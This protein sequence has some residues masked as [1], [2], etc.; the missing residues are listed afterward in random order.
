MLEQN[1]PATLAASEDTY[2]EILRK[3]Q[4]LK[5]LAKSCWEKARRML[6][7]EGR[8]LRNSERELEYLFTQVV[9][10]EHAKIREASKAKPATF[11]AVIKAK[12]L[13]QKA[14]SDLALELRQAR[15][16]LRDLRKPLIAAEAT[17]AVELR[18]M[19]KEVA[20]DIRASRKRAAELRAFARTLE[21]KVANEVRELW[22]RLSSEAISRSELERRAGKYPG[23]PQ[24]MVDATP[25]GEGLPPTSGIYFLWEA[26]KVVYVGKSIRLCNRLR[27][28]GHH[29]LA[30]GHRISFVLIPV[31]ELDWAE[32]FYI[33]VLRPELNFGG[34]NLTESGSR[35]MSRSAA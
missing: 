31:A 9:V 30:A 29:V 7:P 3:E 11:N 4:F 26:E 2:A 14:R 13:R 24:P 27:R 35:I 32:S 33:G 12:E 8:L 5:H 25:T 20:D 19:R 22:E 18:R 16:R 10:R 23:V 17:F 15:Q 6:G 1:Q 21:D 34:N 28:P